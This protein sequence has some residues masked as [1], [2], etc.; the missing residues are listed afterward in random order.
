M[1]QHPLDADLDRQAAAELEAARLKSQGEQDAADIRQLMDT[2]FGQRFVARLL[3]ETAVH[4]TS[5]APS[6]QVMAM[7]EGRKMVGYWLVGELTEHAPDD[8]FNLLRNYARS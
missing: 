1:G 3:S 7:N 8:Y 5:F 4:R 6:G 2:P